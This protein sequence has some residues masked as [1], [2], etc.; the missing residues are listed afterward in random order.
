MSFVKYTRK[1]ETEFLKGADRFLKKDYGFV[2]Y[3]RR[4]CKCILGV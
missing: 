2:F 3:A 1:S 4:S